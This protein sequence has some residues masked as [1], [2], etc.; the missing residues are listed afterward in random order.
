VLCTPYMPETEEEDTDMIDTQNK[1]PKLEVI[2]DNEDDIPYVDDPC[3]DSDTSVDVKP[4]SL[5]TTETASVEQPPPKIEEIIA[6]IDEVTGTWI[7]PVPKQ[8]KINLDEVRLENTDSDGHYYCIFCDEKFEYLS[9][10]QFHRRKRHSLKQYRLRKKCLLCS[11]TELNNYEEHMQETHP[12]FQPNKCVLC[13]QTYQ[14]YQD[15]KAHMNMHATGYTY[16][17]QDCSSYFS[18][19]H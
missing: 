11:K 5:V 15:L 3:I 10:L 4:V 19:N 16:K 6:D 17:C 8:E 7:D 2:S 1:E 12:E 18:K 14:N 13:P 9:E